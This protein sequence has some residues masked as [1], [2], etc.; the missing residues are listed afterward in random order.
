MI[1]MTSILL[2]LAVLGI[3]RLALDARA[4]IRGMMAAEPA[5]AIL[6]PN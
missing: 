1:A 2:F 3:G 4:A 6:P 5:P